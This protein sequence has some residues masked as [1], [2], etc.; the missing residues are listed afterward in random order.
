MIF[1]TASGM[2]DTTGHKQILYLI[3][4]P[5]NIFS[6]AYNTFTINGRF[7]LTGLFGYFA[8][9]KF[10][11][12]YFMIIFYAIF[13]MILIYGEKNIY[14]KSKLNIILLIFSLLLA[15]AIVFGSLYVSWSPYKSSL[16][17]GVQGRYFIPLL[18]LF[19]FIFIPKKNKYEVSNETLY[20]FING[21]LL[22]YLLYIITYFY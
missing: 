11:L 3:H 1:F 22:I 12:N 17:V 7:Y 10:H 4:N 2:I 5:F 20:G 21:S 9:F 19:A 16:V 8:G 13:F 18:I 6:I 15:I 14:K